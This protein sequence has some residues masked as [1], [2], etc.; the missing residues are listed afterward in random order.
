MEKRLFEIAD[1]NKKIIWRGYFSHMLEAIN[2]IETNDLIK[3]QAFYIAQADED[4]S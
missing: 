2:F 3:H 1:K 4:I